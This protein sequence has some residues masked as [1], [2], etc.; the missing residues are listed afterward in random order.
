MKRRPSAL[1]EAIKAR[2]VKRGASA[3]KRRVVLGEGHPWYTNHHN[4]RPGMTE[5]ALTGGTTV[6]A[7]DFV[8]LSYDGTGNWNR[9]RLV[10][11]VLE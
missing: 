5:I 3:V 10:L 6:T 1:D 4:L 11:E 9:V 7:E 2:G 8:S